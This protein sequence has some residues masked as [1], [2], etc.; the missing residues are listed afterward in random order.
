MS[1]TV[2]LVLQSRRPKPKLAPPFR[3]LREVA[4]RQRSGKGLR[5]PRYPNSTSAFCYS[6]LVDVCGT[7]PTD[8]LNDKVRGMQR[9]RGQGR[10][11]SAWP[12]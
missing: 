6:E 1:V 3:A 8:V 12:G 5:L 9:R 10:F 4:M 2:F 11:T 7:A